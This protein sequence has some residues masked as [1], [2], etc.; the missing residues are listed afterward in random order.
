MIKFTLL[1]CVCSFLGEKG[2]LSP[3]QYPTLY[4]T[5]YEC[6]RAALKESSALFSRMGYKYVND[7]RIGIKYHC[8]ITETS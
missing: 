6:S 4:N 2:C 7:N 1:L 5:W 3:I 8:Q